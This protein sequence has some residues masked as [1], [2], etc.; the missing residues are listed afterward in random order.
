MIERMSTLINRLL[1][2]ASKFVATLIISLLSDKPRLFR[3][4]TQHNICIVISNIEFLE[5]PIFTWPRFEI[6]TYKDSDFAF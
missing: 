4:N 2:N 3:G 6:I 5:R 1:Q